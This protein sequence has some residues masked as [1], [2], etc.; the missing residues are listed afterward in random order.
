MEPHPGQVPL[1]GVVVVKCTLENIHTW[2]DLALVYLYLAINLTSHRLQMQPLQN[3]HTYQHQ[4]QL[5]NCIWQTLSLNSCKKIYIIYI[6]VQIATWSKCNDCMTKL[7][8]QLFIIILCNTEKLIELTAFTLTSFPS[9][10]RH[11]SR[12]SNH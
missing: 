3:H 11:G 5:D 6:N 8:S 9:L 4:S 1:G 2:Y 7:Y 10:L 12:H